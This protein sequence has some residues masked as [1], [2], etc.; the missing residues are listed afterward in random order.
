[1]QTA[2]LE[3][4]RNG[5]GSLAGIDQFGWSTAMA[6]VDVL[7]HLVWNQT[8]KQ[9]RDELFARIAA[10]FALDADGCAFTPWEHNYGSLLILAWLLDDLDDRLPF[11]IDTLQS[12]P[13]GRL[14]QWLSGATSDQ[15]TRLRMILVAGLRKRP[16]SQKPWQSWLTT[17]PAA[18]GLRAR[19]EAAPRLYGRERLTALPQSGTDR[20]SAPS[21]RNCWFRHGGPASRR[22]RPPISPRSPHGLLAFIVRP[23]A[24]IFGSWIT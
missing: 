4:K 17:L 12:R 13:L 7:L 20:R 21:Q 11:T 6:L 5:T 23:S 9:D 14:I 19:A 10:D 15:R 3:I 22:M 2:L 8:L 24:S 18:A 1:L 16:R